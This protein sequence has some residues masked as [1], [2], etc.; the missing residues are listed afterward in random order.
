MKAEKQTFTPATV[1]IIRFENGD[2]IVTASFTA[3]GEN[4]TGDP[5][6]EGFGGGF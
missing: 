6:G 3:T 1:E 4:G 5:F 2:D